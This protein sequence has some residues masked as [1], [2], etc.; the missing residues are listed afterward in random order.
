M[1]DK[2][3]LG[4]VILNYLNWKDTIELI[5]S[6]RKQ[7][8]EDYYVVIVDNASSNSSSKNLHQR[9]DQNTNY[10]IIDSK[11]NIGFAR[12]NNLGIS[13]LKT[14]KNIKKILVMNNDII[15]TD[16]FY[17][18][19]LMS[20][21]YDSDV[22]AVGTQIIGADGINQN[23]IVG[24]KVGWLASTLSFLANPL[25][26]SIKVRIKQIINKKNPDADRELFHKNKEEV[27]ERDF[28]LHN[29]VILFTENYL[30]KFDGFYPG[31][32][33]FFEENILAILFQK[34]GL[35]FHYASKLSIYHKEDQSSLMAW[36]NNERYKQKFLRNSIFESFKVL[37]MNKKK[38]LKYINEE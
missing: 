27:I 36:D 17:L 21:E 1:K 3:S 5:D 28:F 26:P 13:Y 4:I 19:K 7:T 18:E 16:K 29:S 33:L 6:L 25:P 34:F 23:P 38:L 20:I 31:T 12:G 30:K 24:V 35:K 14:E 22:G 8:I 32:F 2:F 10:K 9:Y 37:F 11:E 15:F